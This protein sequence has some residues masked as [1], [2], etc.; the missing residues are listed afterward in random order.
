METKVQKTNHST[1]RDVRE[2]CERYLSPFQNLSIIHLFHSVTP[3]IFFLFLLKW[4]TNYMYFKSMAR[5]GIVQELC[6]DLCLLCSCAIQDLKKL[7]LSNIIDCILLGQR[8]LLLLQRF[9]YWNPVGCPGKSQQLLPHVSEDCISHR[10]RF[11]GCLVL[12]FQDLLLCIFFDL[13]NFKL[14]QCP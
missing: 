3:G 8:F 14:E 10:T 13:T 7:C 1:G 9:A 12:Q 6:F 2:V 5:Y 11:C 4:L